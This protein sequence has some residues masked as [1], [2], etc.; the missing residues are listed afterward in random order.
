MALL[1]EEN[2]MLLAL[3]IVYENASLSVMGVIFLLL[4]CLGIVIKISV[5]VDVNEFSILPPFEY[6]ND[7]SPGCYLI[8]L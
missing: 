5:T 1:T 4:L 6:S 8:Y 3:F 7:L 2:E